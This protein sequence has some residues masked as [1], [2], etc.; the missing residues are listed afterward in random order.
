MDSQDMISWTG[1]LIMDKIFP[2]RLSAVWLAAHFKEIV[3]KQS[4]LPQTV[5]FKH[6]RK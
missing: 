6:E 3:D 2:E 4:F 1:F 5:S